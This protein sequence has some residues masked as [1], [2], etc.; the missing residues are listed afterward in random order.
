MKNSYSNIGG[1]FFGLMF[2]AVSISTQAQKRTI[3][4]TVTS[5]E[6]PLAGATVS[7]EGSDEVV[8]T[9]KNGTYQLEVAKENPILL[10]RHPDY[11]E[12]T[13]TANNQTVVNISLEQKV[14][15]IEE[16]ILNAGYYKVKDRERTGSIAKVSAKDIE[17]QPVNNVLSA[18]QGRVAGVSITQNSSV[19]GGGY[20]VQIRGRSSLRSYATTGTDGNRPLYIVD[21]VPLPQINDFN[22]GM[23]GTILP[24]S[25]TNPLNSI[26]PDDIESLEVLKDADATAIYGSK[27]ANGVILIT[28]KKGKKERTEVNLR[29]SYGIGEMT[30]LP[31][32]MNLEEYTAMRKRAFKNDGVAVPSNAYDINGV[33]NPTKFTDWQ[34]YFVGNRAE[35]SDVQI[36]ISGG[37][38]STQFSVTGGHNEETT[39][40]PGNYRYTRNNLSVNFNHTSSDRKFQIAFNGTGSLQD[41]VLPPTDFNLVYAGLTPNAPDLYMSN[42]MIN[43]ENNTFTNPMAAATQTYSVKTKSLNANITT[44][45]AI[46]KGFSL[47]LNNGY[48]TYNADDQKIFPKTTY[49]PSSN[50]G[51]SNSSTRKGQK[52]NQSWILEPQ[53]NYE[54]RLENH[55]FSALLGGSLQEQK[56]D[57]IVLLGRNFPSDEMLTNIA[58]AAT[59]T[60]PSANESLYRYQALYARFN[61]GYKKR[62]FINLTGRRDGS[63]RF[64]SDRRYANFGAVGAAWLF[65]E[66]NFLKKQSWLSF[67]KLRTSYGV[68]GNDQIGDYQYYDTYQSTGGSYGGSSGIIP[69]RLYNK[70]FGWEVTRK[71]EVA[72]ELGLLKQRL[73]FNVGYYHNTSSNQ[74]IGIPMPGTVGFTTIQANLDATVR[75]RGLE[76]SVNTVNI[77]NDQWKWSTNLNFTLPENKLLEFPNLEKSTYANRFEIGKSTSM[78]K[79]Y[80]Y[81]G[82]NPVTGLYTFNDVNKDGVMN[83]ADRIISKEIKEYWYGGLQNSIQ[84]K[85]WSFDVLLQFIKQSQYNINSLYGNIGYMT[86]MPAVF[87]DYWTPDNPDAQFQQP[88]AGF[89]PAAATASSLFNSSDATVSDMFTVRVKNATL[90]YA[91]PTKEKTR[92][93]VKVF[94]S[95]QNL[96]VFSDYKEGNP[97]FTVA[98]YSSP[99]RVISFGLTL[100]Y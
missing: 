94:M 81:T 7:Q 92:M 4:G 56:S 74:L 85:N 19:P 27:G 87:N 9:G 69:Q 35:F 62:Y 16:V 82:I 28:T 23:S 14:K 29:T 50:I 21:G 100:T 70:N 47:N 72:L 18:L 32:M 95:G 55:Q 65:S 15:G 13:I 54:K 36:G 78:V 3:S 37:S 58:A 59:I 45:Y 8:I 5:S 97:E 34:K 76:V 39:V 66:E 57:N 42:G 80:Q 53:L 63:S 61:Y 11:A 12:K 25:E 60:I 22:T 26:N 1:I 64:G 73:N 98:G 10:F 51:S 83:S 86:N 48:S 68:A 43:W 41:N 44:S 17:N 93:K 67:G 75:N 99:L 40:F 20:D 89:N 91:I 88:S 49:N 24:Y 84:Y 77:Q 6:Q 96:F 71:F 31:K 52:L 46:G 79:L 38:G 90:S 30:N 2:T 33:W